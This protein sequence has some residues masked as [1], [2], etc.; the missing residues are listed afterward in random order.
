V[1]EIIPIITA[2]VGAAG[3]GT[4]IY[5]LTNQPGAPKP[6]AAA[7]PA[8]VSA[9]ATKNRAAQE[10]SLSNQFPSIQAQTG[11]SL[12]PEAWLRL[13]ELLSGKAGEA[14]IGSAGQDLLAKQAVAS[15]S[16][17]TSPNTGAGL[18]TSGYGV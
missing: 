10:A 7:T 1:P 18:S 5:S 2:I 13:A 6:P 15:G 12:A 16:T 11:G 4:S 14:G 3:V 17:S 8:Q 9:D